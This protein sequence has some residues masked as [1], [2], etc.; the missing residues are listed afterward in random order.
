MLEFISSLNHAVE[1]RIQITFT[2][3]NLQQIDQ[4]WITGAMPKVHLEF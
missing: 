1:Q 3:D 2:D 4:V